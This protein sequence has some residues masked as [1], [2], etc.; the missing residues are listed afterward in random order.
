MAVVWWHVSPVVIVIA[1]C[2]AQCI[3]TYCRYLTA[4]VTVIALLRLPP[5]SSPLRSIRATL[6]R[7]SPLP[8]YSLSH[9]VAQC[10]AALSPIVT[11]ICIR[12]NAAT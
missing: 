8:H 6:C 9:V 11:L 5:P 4:Y 12:H 7:L 3:A 2:A 10:A 1:S